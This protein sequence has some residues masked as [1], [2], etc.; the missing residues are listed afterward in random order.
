[1][2][3]VA[4]A[5][6]AVT[7]VSPEWIAFTGQPAAEAAGHG[8]FR[9]VYPDDYRPA[10]EFQRDVRDRRCEFSLRLRLRR[11]EG[12][13]TW[14]VIG[15]VPSFGPPGH[16]FLGFLESMTEI[17]PS[18]SEPLSAYGTLGRFAPPPPHPDTLPSSAL[19]LVADHLLMA[20]GLVEQDH[21][22]ELLPVL[23]QAL[24]V[25]GTPLSRGMA[26]SEQPDRF[27]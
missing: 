18:G 13:H 23:R 17:G 8:W 5:D 7:H 4:N 24:L 6:G 26:S 21:G 12:S 16:T 14:V 10:V 1:M 20:H 25:A 27:H 11:P 15:A 3:F 2:I 9:C 22:K 19:E